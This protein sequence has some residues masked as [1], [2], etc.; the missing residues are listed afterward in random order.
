MNKL[1][2]TVVLL[3]M[4]G[5]VYAAGTAEQEA[6]FDKS[7][8]EVFSAVDAL[9]GPPQG[10]FPGHGDHGVNFQNPGEHGGNNPPPVSQPQPVQP[11][12]GPGH[13]GHFGPGH[14][15]HPGPGHDD[16]FGPQPQPW[17]P[18]PGHDDHFGPQPQPWHPQ[19][20][21]WHPQHQPQPEPWHYQPQP[22]PYTPSAPV[23]APASDISL[24]SSGKIGVALYLT[25]ADSQAEY[26]KGSKLDLTVE[27]MALPEGD[28]SPQEILHSGITVRGSYDA[29]ALYSIKL[30]ENVK[31]GNYILT[32]KFNRR[33]DTSAG[34][35][36]S[37][38]EVLN[39]Q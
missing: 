27:A 35:D 29:D 36:E 33:W 9:K 25:F 13:D 31:P 10:G 1:V 39:V 22:E 18:G 26:Y 16:H 6:G 15:N 3:G 24:Q 12:Y 20:Q 5:S 28:M 17:S 4:T 2:M 38:T 19:P 23:T 8:S 32:V 11:Q 34:P 14:D 21:P 30:G 7:V 37:T